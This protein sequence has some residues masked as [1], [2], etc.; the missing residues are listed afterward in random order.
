M[1]WIH[2]S[3]DTEWLDELKNKTQPY[4]AFRGQVLALK[5]NR[6]RVKGWKIM[7]QANSNQKKWV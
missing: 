7:L 4:A 3:K 5:T 1:V 2:Q 6:L